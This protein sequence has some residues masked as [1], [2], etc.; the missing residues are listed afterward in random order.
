[1]GVAPTGREIL[2]QNVVFN[3][4]EAGRIAER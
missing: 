1:M 2:F 3:R 4:M